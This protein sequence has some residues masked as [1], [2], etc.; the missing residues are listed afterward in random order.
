[1]EVF[2]E[3]LLVELLFIAIQVALMRVYQWIRARSGTSS[4]S[5]VLAAA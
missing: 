5:E 3:R 4:A 2:L 1:M